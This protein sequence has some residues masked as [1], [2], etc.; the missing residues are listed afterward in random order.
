MLFDLFTRCSVGVTASV[1]VLSDCPY[2]GIAKMPDMSHIERG[3]GCWCASAGESVPRTVTS[4]DA[5]RATD[6]EVVS[7][8]QRH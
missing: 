2:E 7:Q 3:W 1:A 6:P 4:L 8:L 5:R